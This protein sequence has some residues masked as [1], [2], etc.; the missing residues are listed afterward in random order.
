MLPNITGKLGLKGALAFWGSKQQD[1]D[2]MINFTYDI[3]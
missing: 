3:I 1:I 2:L